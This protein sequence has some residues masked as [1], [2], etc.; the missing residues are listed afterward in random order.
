M[1]FLGIPVAFVALLVGWLLG[2]ISPSLTSY[3]QQA[4]DR[5]QLTSAILGELAELEA[6]MAMLAA[7]HKSY[8]GLDNAFIEWVLQILTR[9]TGA[10]PVVQRF[11]QAIW[12]LLSVPEEQRKLEIMGFPELRLSRRYLLPLTDANMTRLGICSLHFQQGV[13]RVKVALEDYNASIESLE[14]KN[15]EIY[16]RTGGKISHPSVVF[17]RAQAHIAPARVAQFIVNEIAATRIAS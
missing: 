8:H 2:L 9:Y 17:E 7:L 14:Q 3:F 11:A 12:P 1:D 6:R 16:A 15:R 10:D 13:S 4:R 5:K